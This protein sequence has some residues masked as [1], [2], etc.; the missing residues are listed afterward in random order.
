MKKI[1]ALSLIL[2]L[3]LAVFVGCGGTD[4]PAPD[5]SDPAATD[6]APDTDTDTGEQPSGEAVTLSTFS[7]YAGNDGNAENYQTAL[8]QWQE[9]TGNT[10][11]DSSATA[12]E[13]VKAKIRTDFTTGSEPDLL[14]YFTGS[15]A[16]PFLDKVVPVDEI[17]AEYPDYANNMNEDL[18]PRATDGTWYAVP[19]NGYWENMFVN[20]VVLEAAGVDIPGPDYTWEQFLTDCETIKGAGYT[21]IAASFVDVPHYWWEFAIF[22]N[23]TPGTHLNVP[24]SVDDD[25]GKAWI[26][27]MQDIKD[28]Y[29]KGYFPTNV[30]SEKDEAIQELLYT[31]KAA[32]MID[33]SWRA[34]TIKTRCSDA[35]ENLDAERLADFTV[36]NVPAKGGRK[37]TDMITGMSSGWYISRKAWDDP[38]KRDACVNFVSYMT[39]NDM[40]SDFTGT[41]ASALK[42]GVTLDAGTLDSLDQDIL[43]MLSNMTS[44]TPAVQDIVAGEARN[45]MFQSVPQMVSGKIT[46]Q[47]HVEDFLAAFE[48]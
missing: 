47:E 9:V 3:S 37:A 20:K 11:N 30:L 48:Q 4:Q 24:A 34:N 27:G 7:T 42:D 31:D 46:P 26:A 13:T 36:V 22:N 35:D 1:I 17:R 33:G 28:L 8:A 10:I 18:V 16:D 38:A 15:D 43:A 2:V 5:A 29:E 39:S 40:V 19:V 44:S 32:F 45:T 12:D 21:P 23:D 41:G 25:A 14:F 6:S